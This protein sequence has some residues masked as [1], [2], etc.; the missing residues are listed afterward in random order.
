VRNTINDF[1][2]YLINDVYT[3]LVRL[4]I[5]NR[6]ITLCLTLALMFLTIGL[7]G[8]GYIKFTP[9]PSWDENLIQANIEFPIGTSAEITEKA[10]LQIGQGLQDYIDQLDIEDNDLLIE[11]VFSIAGQTPG[12]G[13]QYGTHLGAMTVQLQHSNFRSIHS[14]DIIAGWERHTP[15][16]NGALSQTFSTS[17]SGPGGTPIEIW[18]RGDNT[19]NLRAIAKEIRKKL[20]TYE[21]VFQVE[22]SFRP[23]KRELKVNV[24]PESLP[25]GITQEDLARQIYA[26]FYGLEADRIQR[27]RDDVRIKVRY[28]GE[29]RSSLAQL[30]RIRVRTSQGTE[31]PFLSVADVQ[32]GSGL[33]TIDRADGQRRIMVTADVDEARGNA[34]EILNEL[35]R[36]FFPLLRQKYT[37]FSI[38]LEGSRQSSNES[39]RGLM[40]LFPIAMLAIFIVIA[41]LFRSYT[42]P[43]IVMITVPFGLMGAILGHVIL[44]WQVV[45]F[46]I[47]GM[48]ALTGVVVNDAIVLI[49][50]VNVQIAKGS[51]I[52]DAIVQGATRRFRAIMLTTISTI[53]ALIPII[54]ETDL[55]AQPLNPMALSLACGVGLASG[56]TLIFVPSL[57]AILS[58]ARCALH[59]LIKGNWP[60]R[61]ELEPAR[62]RNKDIFAH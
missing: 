7:G 57:L 31:V 50:A 2:D 14:K 22:D 16:I 48:M 15:R 61:E 12:Q 45:M 17:D 1:T 3:T 52:F 18:L 54:I 34:T 29:E 6:Y 56:L 59:F 19:D 24:K 51:K 30:E 46:S 23:G 8:A 41:T 43:M 28:Q 33:A 35:Q 27:G 44:G 13:G 60:S 4:A 36:D 10:L 58:D 9:F 42:Q 40:A 11:H 20:L 32:Y 38:S 53:G 26:G 21:G 37:G 55:S 62:N 47:F 39:I 25:L 49:E 5:T